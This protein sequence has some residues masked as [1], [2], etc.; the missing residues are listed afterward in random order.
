MSDF[1]PRTLDPGAARV[2]ALM[3]QA[4][5]ATGVPTAEQA[6]EAFRIG[7]RNLNAEPPTIASVEALRAPGPGGSIPLRLYRG[8]N[9]A[10][11]EL[12]PALVFFIR[13]VGSSATLIPTTVFAAAWP[14]LP[15]AS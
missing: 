3:R 7:R 2:V 6:R 4:P 1:Q 15:A 11:G 5:I 9:V 13:E 12:L 10:A 14:A 8:V